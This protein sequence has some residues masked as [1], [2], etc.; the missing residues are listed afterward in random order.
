MNYK[1]NYSPIIL[2][3]GDFLLMRKK[4]PVDIYAAHVTQEKWTEYCPV[5]QKQ[6]LVADNDN[7]Q[8]LEEGYDLKCKKCNLAFDVEVVCQP[9]WE[10]FSYKHNWENGWSEHLLSETDLYNLM[11]WHE[12]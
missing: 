12:E 4:S 2:A 6:Q 7:E 8:T 3:N 9:D 10:D 1:L 11:E 5:C